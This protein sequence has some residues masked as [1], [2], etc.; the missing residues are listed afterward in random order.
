ML[1]DVLLHIEPC[2]S[3]ERA[4]GQK[5]RH[6]LILACTQVEAEWKAVLRANRYA[7]ENAGNNWTRKDYKELA[8]VMRLWEWT[9]AFEA[10]RWREFTPFS[11]WRPNASPDKMGWY[12]AYNAVKH[13]GLEELSAASLLNVVEALA[14]LAVMLF[15]QF[16]PDNCIPGAPVA[17]RLRATS[18][19]TWRPNERYHATRSSPEPVAWWSERT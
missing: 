8:P 5:L 11:A 6:L 10:I 3:N 17:T 13:D 1:E 2:D 18:R 16:E 15:A 19:P 12:D 4:F 9:V 7:A 14:A